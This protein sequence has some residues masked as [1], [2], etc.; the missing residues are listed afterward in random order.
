[1]TFSNT[2]HASGRRMLPALAALAAFAAAPALA[3]TDVCGNEIIRDGNGNVTYQFIVSGDPR[4]DGAAASEAASHNL[5]SNEDTALAALFKSVLASFGG[6]L[7]SK[8]WQG[9]FLLLR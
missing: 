5:A 3:E 2:I 8:P 9:F 1:M 6:R 7:S 4:P